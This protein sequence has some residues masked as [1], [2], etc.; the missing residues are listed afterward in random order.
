[1]NTF[2]FDLDGTLLPMNQETF[3]EAY[4]NALAIK[5]VPHGLEPKK[6]IQS[7]WS[8]TKSMIEN[9]GSMSNEQRFWNTFTGIEGE[10]MRRLEPIFDEFYRKEF[11]TARKATTMNPYAKKCIQLLKEKGYRIV[12]ATNPLFPRIATLNRIEWAGLDAENFDL[13]TTYENSSYCKPNL[14]YYRAILKEIGRTPEECTMVGND[15]K[16]DMCAAKLGM[17]TYLLK[18]CLINTEAEDITGYRQGDFEELFG[19]IESLPELVS[20]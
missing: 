6:L 16:E 9:D 4:F 8:G 20:S 7:V 10:E 14:E 19:Y 15:I 13:I 17:Q 5:M 18:D 11:H 3:L 2:I 1:M 12:L